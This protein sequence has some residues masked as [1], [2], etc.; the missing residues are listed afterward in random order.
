M[1]GGVRLLRTDRGGWKEVEVVAKIYSR[2]RP[3][4]AVMGGG[5]MMRGDRPQPVDDGRSILVWGFWAVVPDCLR[6]APGPSVACQISKPACRVECITELNSLLLLVPTKFSR[7]LYLILRPKRCHCGAKHPVVV[8]ALCLLC[9]H[10]HASPALC[11]VSD[12]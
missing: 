9:F 2:G 1:G 11:S 10:I 7:L 4:E 5:A 3:D 12:S 6:A 8:D